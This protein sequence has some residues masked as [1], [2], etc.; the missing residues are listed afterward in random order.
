[1]RLRTE[2]GR[3]GSRGRKLGTVLDELW[4]QLAPLPLCACPQVHIQTFNAV[5]RHTPLCLLQLVSSS[6]PQALIYFPLL[7]RA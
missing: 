2:K 5:S 4:L 1:M 3:V 7:Y 6:E